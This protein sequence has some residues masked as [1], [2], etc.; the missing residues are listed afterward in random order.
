MDQLIN[1]PIK[2]FL[3]IVFNS[4]ILLGAISL[5]TFINFHFGIYLSN[6]VL[7]LEMKPFFFH[8]GCDFRFEK[9]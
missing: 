1:F 3:C 4:H 5:T 6:Y 2:P 9:D 7:A 8:L